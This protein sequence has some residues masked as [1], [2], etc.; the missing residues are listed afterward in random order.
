MPDDRPQE[1]VIE[2]DA[3][4]DAYMKSYM[5]DQANEATASRESK[6]R[7]GGVKS[8]WDHGETIVMRSNP[9]YEDVEYSDTI[10]SMKNKRSTD[11][12]VKQP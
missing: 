9:V 6:N 11:L 4:L 2:D 8:A 5:D 10:E 3:S 7:G 12:K 1:S